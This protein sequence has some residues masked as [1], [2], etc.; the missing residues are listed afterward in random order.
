MKTEVLDIDLRTRGGKT[1]PA[2]LYHRV[3]FAADGAPGPSRTLVLNRARSDGNDP[4]RAA[5]VRF[6]R[7]FHN[8]P[9]AIAAVDRAGRIAGTMRCWRACFRACSRARRHRRKVAPSSPSSPSATPG[10]W[11][12]GTAKAAGGQGDV[13]C[14]SMPRLQARASVGRASSLTAVEDEID[15][16]RAIREAP[17]DDRAARA[18]EERGGSAQKINPVGKL[19]G[20]IDHDFNNVLSA[21]MMATDFLLNA[22]K[23]TRP[24]LPPGHHADQA[25]REPRRRA[26]AP[27]CSPSFAARRC[28]TR[29]S[30]STKL[31]PT[32]YSMLLKRLIGED[33]A[34]SRSSPG[35]ACGR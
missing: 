6:M 22:H 5:E 2:R 32:R 18:A 9:M 31:C 15:Q 1:L 27:S 23:P 28:V 35:A 4:Q 16:E 17:G 24:V 19:A 13:C 33:L 14:R 26:G 21:I 29:C 30:I 20:D 11:R 3:A 10:R 34:A 12:R 7:F 8:T 25:E